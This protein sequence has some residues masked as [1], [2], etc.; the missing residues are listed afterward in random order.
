MASHPLDNPVWHALAGPHASL[1]RRSGNVLAY[2]PEVALFAAAEDPATSDMQ[3]LAALIPDGATVGFPFAGDIP[4]PA[5]VELVRKVDVLQ[6]VAD[7]FVPVAITAPIVP[8]GAEHQAA[9]VELVD[10]TKPG[11]F[12][13]EAHRM[14]PFN[15]IFDGE[16]LAAMA[17]ERMTLDGYSE[18]SAVCT[19]PDYRGRGYAKQLVSLRAGDIVARGKTPFL[20]VFPDNAAAIA[21]YERLGFVVR[22][23]MTFTVVRRR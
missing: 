2:R 5:N 18:V 23:A 11:P 13:P 17:G 4:L 9:M 12:A 22:R 7:H 14:G 19:H 1:S 6:M 8:I 15:G 3:G 16:R 20:H 10:M 21:T